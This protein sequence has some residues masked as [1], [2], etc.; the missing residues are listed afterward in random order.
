LSTV[1][2]LHTTTFT[3]MATFKKCYDIDTVDG[4]FEDA[5]CGD[6][7]YPQCTSEDPSGFTCPQNTLMN[8]GEPFMPPGKLILS[9]CYTKSTST[10]TIFNH[11]VSSLISIVC[12][13]RELFE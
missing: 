7:G 1:S 8:T 12:P 13:C 2:N 6:M 10:G 4:Q 11:Y 9:F 3:E 5:C